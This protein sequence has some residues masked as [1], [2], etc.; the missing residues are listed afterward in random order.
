MDVAI[1]DGMPLWNEEANVEKL[2]AIAM[3]IYCYVYIPLNRLII[4]LD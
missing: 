4:E 2:V 3:Y 1:N